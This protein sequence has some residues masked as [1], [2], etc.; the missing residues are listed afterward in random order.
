[1]GNKI[2]LFRGKP[3]ADKPT[4]KNVVSVFSVGPI[5][6]PLNMKPAAPADGG[7]PRAAAIYAGAATVFAV[8]AVYYLFTGSW[9]TGLIM[10]VPT[11][12]LAG[13]AWYYMKP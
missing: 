5:A 3:S 13:F 2:D 1:M 8:I 7:L 4:G 10:I 12:C 11:G 6:T 9:I